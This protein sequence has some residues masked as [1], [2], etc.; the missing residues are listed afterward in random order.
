MAAIHEKR[1]MAKSRQKEEEMRK[2]GP[3]RN[4][5]R[6]RENY[7]A[8]GLQHI[9]VLIRSKPVNSCQKCLKG[10]IWHKNELDSA[11]HS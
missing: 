9:K 5:K 2:N 10:L 11:L 4:R 6:K 3:E 7:H 1:L 8:M